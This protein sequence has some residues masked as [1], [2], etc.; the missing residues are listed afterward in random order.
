MRDRIGECTREDGKWT[1]FLRTISEKHLAQVSYNY[2]YTEEW[3][4]MEYIKARRSTFVWCTQCLLMALQLSFQTK[5]G[6]T[7]RRVYFLAPNQ[8]RNHE[9]TS[10]NR[11]TRRFGYVYA[12]VNWRIEGDE[13]F[14]S[15]KLF[16]G[17]HELIFLMFFQFLT[18]SSSNPVSRI[19]KCNKLWIFFTFHILL[20]FLHT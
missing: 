11:P 5:Q 3:E 9:T 15:I 2:R 6:R 12:V 18:F 16:K 1:L 8:S 7:V 20:N 10:E 4:Y 13:T 14:H 17:R 19:M